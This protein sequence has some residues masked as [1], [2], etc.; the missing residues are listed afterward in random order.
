MPEIFNEIIDF[1][2]SPTFNTLQMVVIGYFGL[3]WVAIIIWVTRD[4]IHRSSSLI[5][6]TFAILINIAVPI[7]GVLLY[8]IIRPS[9]TNLESYYEEL[10][11][12]LLTESGEDKS[13]SCEKCLSL[14]SKD[15]SFCPNCGEKTKKACGKCKKKF[16]SAYDI[17]PYCGENQKSEVKMVKKHISKK[18]AE[19]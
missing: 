13:I 18:T 2:S 6:Q 9:K 12:R 4:S 7:L 3:L 8:L 16:P 17:C 5:F 15:Y 1:C 14:V 10:E 19:K 11:H